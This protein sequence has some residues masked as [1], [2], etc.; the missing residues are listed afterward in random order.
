MLD[1]FPPSL[2]SDTDKVNGT[3]WSLQIDFFPLYLY[4]YFQGRVP[5]LGALTVPQI[6]LASLALA[7]AQDLRVQTAALQGW[8]VAPGIVMPRAG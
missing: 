8:G 4:I 6:R 5:G 3:I 7:P 2:L 1:T